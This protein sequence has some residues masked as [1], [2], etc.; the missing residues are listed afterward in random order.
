MQPAGA[1][2]RGESSEVAFYRVKASI[3]EEPA[4]GVRLGGNAEA[5][6][7][8]FLYAAQQWISPF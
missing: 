7:S 6:V 1:A 4:I 8:F 3:C 2:Q 5:R